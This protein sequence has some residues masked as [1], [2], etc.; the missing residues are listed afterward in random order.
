MFK[1]IEIIK[2]AF[3]NM[4]TVCDNCAS[5]ECQKNDVLVWNRSEELLPEYGYDVLGMNI[6][7]G[8]VDFGFRSLVDTDIY[9]WVDFEF[10]VTHWAY[11]NWPDDCYD[12]D[13]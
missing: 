12:Y 6:D 13:E 1:S 9:K 3:D 5:I 2:K 7:S 11:A 4:R 10:E 8:K